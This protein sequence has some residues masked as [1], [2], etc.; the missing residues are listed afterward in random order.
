L[1]IFYNSSI[2]LAFESIIVITDDVRFGSFIRYTHINRASMIIALLFFIY[3]EDFFLK[4]TIKKE[5]GL[6]EYS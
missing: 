5:L 3:D 1:S 6:L 2:I 4:V